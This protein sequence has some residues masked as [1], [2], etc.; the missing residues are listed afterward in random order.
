MKR[1]LALGLFAI[2]A[3]AAATRLLAQNPVVGT[4]KLNVAKSKYNPGPGPKSQ[5]RIVEAQGDKTKYSFEGV[6][7]DGSAISY[8]FT[9]GFD[10]KDYPITG[11][12]APGGADTMSIK[13]PSPTSYEATLKKAGEPILISK[14]EISKDGKT[15]TIVQQ[16][17]PG[18]GSV[19]NTAVYD[20]Q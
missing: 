8:T 9:A 1:T 12:G 19:S 4:W 17:A 7:A 10:G 11:S 6:T 14:V 15:T 2:L 5:T 20:K 18:K 16:S 13:Q 3:F